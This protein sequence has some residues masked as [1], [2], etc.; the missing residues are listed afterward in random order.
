MTR[1]VVSGAILSLA[2]GISSAALAQQS[3]TSGPATG[4]NVQPSTAVQKENTQAQSTG[5]AGGSS[6]PATASGAAGAEGK[7]GT[8]AGPAARQPSK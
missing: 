4:G 5:S 6:A 3:S 2:L 8:E 7:P 1:I